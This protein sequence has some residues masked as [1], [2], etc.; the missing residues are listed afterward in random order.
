MFL[1]LQGDFDAEVSRHVSGPIA[2]ANHSDIAGVARVLAMVVTNNVDASSQALIPVPVMQ[3]DGVI[4]SFGTVLCQ[5]TA[6]EALCIEFWI[7]R[8][9]RFR[10]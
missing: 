2:A 5:A 7:Q 6:V 1:A 4:P 9:Q 10:G 8:F 3:S